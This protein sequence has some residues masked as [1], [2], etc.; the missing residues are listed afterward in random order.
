M[1]D[2]HQTQVVPEGPGDVASA[3]IGE[4][5]GTVQNIP[6]L[7]TLPLSGFIG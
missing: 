4:E 3:I 7:Q 1:P 2:A 6:A 5:F